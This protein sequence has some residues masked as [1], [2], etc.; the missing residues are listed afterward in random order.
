MIL[1]YAL[2]PINIVMIVMLIMSTGIGCQ[3][4]NDSPSYMN[5]QF[6]IYLLKDENITS[7]QF[8]QLNLSE[9]EL[10]TEPWL[11]IEDIEFYD[12]STH[13]IYLKED[14]ASLFE[15]DPDA[16]PTGSSS[17][18]F[19]VVA[20]GE[21]SYLGEILSPVSSSGHMVPYI[22][23]GFPIGMSPYP[24]DIIHIIRYP[25]Y[26][27]SYDED[28]RTDE[29]IKDALV[30]AG[31]FQAGLNVELKN[32]EI[33]GEPGTQ[34]IS[35]TIAVTNEGDEDLY[36][37]DPD[38]MGIDLFHFYSR[39]VTLV[40]QDG[41]LSILATDPPGTPASDNWNLEWYTKIQGGESLLRTVVMPCS[42]TVAE[43]SYLCY[44]R[45]SGPQ[46]YFDNS[47][48]IMIERDERTLDSGRLFMGEVC[49]DYI[50][51]TL[52]D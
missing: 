21:I 11:S 24:S 9:L 44:F 27:G 7:E 50:E 6:S 5:D 51:Y 49:S 37:P 38:K 1:C 42:T 33:T 8:Q 48:P 15:R 20:Q 47:D 3:Q 23:E 30:Q 28:V 40:P 12:F 4:N 31:K 14:K 16:F 25:M 34:I 41:G 43:S 13:Y 2:K 10:K 36:V 18:F 39:G 32:V 52:D 45:Y 29:N 35:Y 46:I 19:V 17:K 26:M 22:L